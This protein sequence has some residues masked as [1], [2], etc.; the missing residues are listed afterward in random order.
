[1]SAF[2]MTEKEVVRVKRVPGCSG[3]V[4]VSKPFVSPRDMAMALMRM[5]FE[6]CSASMSHTESSSEPREVSSDAYYPRQET[7]PPSSSSKRN[8]STASYS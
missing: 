8:Q 7:E 2:V 5:C 1:M 4:K 3:W 6:A